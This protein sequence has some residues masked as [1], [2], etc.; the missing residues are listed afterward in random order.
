MRQMAAANRRRML[1][2]SGSLG[3]LGLL[4]LGFYFWRCRR[5]PPEEE[6]YEGGRNYSRASAAGAA[7]WG[8]WE[9]GGGVAPEN[10]ELLVPACCALDISDNASQAGSTISQ[11]QLDNWD[12]FDL[13]DEEGAWATPSRSANEAGL[14][15]DGVL[16]TTRHQLLV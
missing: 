14:E 3:G 2:V 9:W 10:D 16:T 11:E 15:T 12:D 4:L 1:G 7:G 6:E 13:D 5:V 8:G